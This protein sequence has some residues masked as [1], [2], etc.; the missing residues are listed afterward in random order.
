MRSRIFGSELVKNK[1]KHPNANDTYYPAYFRTIDGTDIKLL[2]TENQ[3][4]KARV[5]AEKN[6]EDFAEEKD[7]WSWFLN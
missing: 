4:N 3:I 1:D 7:V 5:R 2:F 6:L